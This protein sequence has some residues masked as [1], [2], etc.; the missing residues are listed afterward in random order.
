MYQVNFQRTKWHSVRELSVCKHRL[1]D[2]EFGNYSCK[3][4]GVFIAPHIFQLAYKNFIL[5]EHWRY[6]SAVKG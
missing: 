2:L 5:T 1:K 6:G 4:A 3:T